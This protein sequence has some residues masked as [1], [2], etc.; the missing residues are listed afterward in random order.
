MSLWAHEAVGFGVFVRRFAV[1][2]VAV[3]CVMLLWASSASALAHKTATKTLPNGVE[4]TTYRVGPFDVTPGQ[5]RIGNRPLI[6]LEK[7]GEDGWIVGM[8]PNLVDEAGN[9]PPSSDVMF[10]HGVFLNMSQPD[11]TSD[12]PWDR[13]FGAGEEKTDLRLPPGYGYRHESKDI[14]ILNHMIHNLTSRPM[15]L[16]ITY[17]IDFV[18]DTAPE[19]KDITPVRAVWMDVRNGSGYPVFDTIKGSGGKDGKTVFPDDQPDAYPDGSEPNKWTVDQ[20]GVIVWT[21]GHVHTGGLATDLYL[22]REG[23]KYAGPRCKKPRALSRRLSKKKRKSLQRKLK[24]CI[25]TKPNVEGDRVHLFKSFAKYY[26]PAGPVSWDV[27]MANT[28]PDYGVAIKKGDELEL[29]TTYE[30][31]RASWYEN[32]GIN[33]VFVAPPEVGGD[34][35]FKKRVDYPGVPNHGHYKEND[36]HGGKNPV[37]GPDPTK[38]PNGIASGGPFDISNFG[39]AAGNFAIPGSNGRPP[40]VEKGQSFTFQM[41]Q[42]DL[43]QEIWHSLTSCKA[44]CNKSTGI[45]YPI[46]DSDFQFDSGQMGIN[47]APTVNRTT[48]STPPDLPVGTHTFFCRIHPFMRGAVRV[49]K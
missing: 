15:K 17:T 2:G 11:V 31:K 33:F 38:L 35:P 19:A 25:R 44:P 43:Q 24:K 7:P 42:S 21:A 18:P 20:D 47:G 5:N 27:A 4:R 8:A 1:V 28:R 9:V 13:F 22:S 48:W 12:L 37:V 46:A 10:H 49:V 23:A 29:T 40:V 34:N 6:G 14:W 32:M 16:Y 3:A 30:S 41:V 45:A 26:E 36:N 39:Y